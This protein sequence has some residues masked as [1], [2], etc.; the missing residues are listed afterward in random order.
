MFWTQLRET[1]DNWR[2][3]D[4]PTL[5]AAVAYYAVFS[6]FPLLLLLLAAMGFA[7]RYSSGAQNAR[8][9][10]LVLVA[11]NASPAL[12]GHVQAVLEQIS[13]RATL[14]GPVALAALLLAAIGVFGQVEL[15]FDRI[16]KSPASGR[17]ERPSHA[18]ACAQARATIR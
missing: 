3:D 1:F 2:N 9:Q 15:A 12:A 6:L 14:G 5:A 13:V 11:Q 18:V 4:G 10:L 17:G 8:Q 16:W 7:L